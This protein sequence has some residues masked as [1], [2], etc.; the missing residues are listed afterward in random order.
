MDST[1]PLTGS[2]V[3][4]FPAIEPTARRYTAPMFPVTSLTSQSGVTTRRQWGNK[5]MRAELELEFSN[6]SAENK[7]AILSVYGEASGS[8]GSLRLPAIVFDTPLTGLVWAF[9]EGSSP[10]V[11]DVPP[12]RYDVSVALVAELR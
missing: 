7:D 2:F 6:I 12:D 9:T 5:A 4:D 1:P 11:D 8:F 3:V 10:S